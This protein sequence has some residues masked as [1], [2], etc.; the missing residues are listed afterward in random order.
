MI[1][2]N[3]LDTFPVFLVQDTIN[4]ASKDLTTQYI[5]WG[6]DYSKQLGL[7][8][9]IQG[10]KA[11]DAFADIFDISGKDDQIAELTDEE[12]ANFMDY[13]KEALRG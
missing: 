9:G 11:G 5:R 7:L 12:Y 4:E 1:N 10:M 3:D 2:G 8:I 6:D 13:I